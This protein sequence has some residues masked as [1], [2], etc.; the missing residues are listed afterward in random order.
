MP[1]IIQRSA[2]SKVTI[3]LS[4]DLV[5][6]LDALTHSTKE[7][8]RSQIIEEAIRKWLNNQNQKEIERQTEEYYRS[9]SKAELKEN[10]EWTKIATRSAKKIWDE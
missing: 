1:T 9:L 4:A 3:T 7:S 10:K 6:K 8:S 5:R 2:K